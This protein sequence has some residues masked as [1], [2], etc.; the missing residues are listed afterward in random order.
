MRIRNMQQAMRERDRRGRT[1]LVFEI[2]PPLNVTA[3]SSMLTTPPP[4]PCTQPAQ[5]CP[6]QSASPVRRHPPATRIG[7]TRIAAPPRTHPL[8]F[9]AGY[10]HGVEQRG[11]LGHDEH[12]ATAG[13][14]TRASPRRSATAKPAHLPIEERTC[15][16]DTAQ[17]T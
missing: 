4:L 9:G 6:P 12:A 13:L 8:C 16:E 17:R 14:R 10:R 7:P 3:P 5:P 2:V 15:T 1:A 11:A